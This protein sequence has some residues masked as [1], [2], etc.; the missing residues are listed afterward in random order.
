MKEQTKDTHIYFPAALHEQIKKLAKQERH[1]L[2]VEIVIAVENHV[3]AKD[4]KKK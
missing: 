1:T 4:G 2:S 3:K